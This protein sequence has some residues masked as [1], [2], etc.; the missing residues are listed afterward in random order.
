M[1]SGQFGDVWKATW[2]GIGL[3]GD[4]IPEV[5]VAAKILKVVGMAE[6]DKHFHRELVNLS[7]LSHRNIIELLGASTL[8]EVILVT[9]YANAGSLFRFLHKDCT[10]SRIGSVVV[11]GWIST[12]AVVQRSLVDHQWGLAVAQL[13]LGLCLSHCKG[14]CGWHGV[15]F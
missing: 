7:K 10:V 8:N 11:R 14:N 1:Y 2:S 9:E 3:N 13:Q 5:V 12:I 15:S 4:V 6:S